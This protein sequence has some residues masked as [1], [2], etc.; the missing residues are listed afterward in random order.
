MTLTKE[1]RILLDYTINIFDQ[2]KELSWK[3]EKERTDCSGT[4]AIASTHALILYYLPEFVGAFK[5]K[6]PRTNFILKG[7]PSETIQEEVYF[8]N[9]DFGIVYFDSVT[10][11][12]PYHPLLES[13]LCL[14]SS[15]KNPF[16]I[17]KKPDLEEL[18][19]LP[20]IQYPLR[21]T[22]R[23]L[24]DK[25]FISAGL[26]INESMTLNHLESI[27]KVV[28]LG[29]G[30]S[31]VFDFVLQE[32]H[33]AKLQIFPLCDYFDKVSIGVII[34]K[35]KHLTPVVRA[36]LRLLKPEIKLD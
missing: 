34:R 24:I 32:H 10:R 6:N 19:R 11:N 15:A 8:G 30:A 23:A 4:I 36:F 17:S 2:V 1:G 31:Y 26:Q 18:S 7:G 27:I 22:T 9:C 21:S 25:A 3:I 5:D 20:T 16:S 35:K 33:K 13:E 12:L 29:L 14:I 28:E